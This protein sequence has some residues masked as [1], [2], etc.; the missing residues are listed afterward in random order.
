MS[1]D[2]ALID[3]THSGQNVTVYSRNWT[4]NY[5]PALN[6]AGLS[7]P[8]W[9]GKRAHELA[10]AVNVALTL[11]TVQPEKHR[12]LIRGGGTSENTGTLEQC[13]QMLTE[14][15]DACTT[16]FAATVSV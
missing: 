16:H 2:V 8:D 9:D 13:R 14:L 4:Y 11:I 7:L 1:Y 5:S 15:L 6:A 10:T 3:T 12:P